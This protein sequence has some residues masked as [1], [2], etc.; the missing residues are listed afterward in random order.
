MVILSRD[1]NFDVIVEE[2][3]VALNKNEKQEIVI[4]EKYMSWLEEFTNSNSEI[5]TKNLEERE[6]V[7][8]NEKVYI[9]KLSLLFSMVENY[10]NENFI[11][12]KGDENKIIYVIMHFF[13]K[14]QYK[15]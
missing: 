13:F 14:F 3:K 2:L 1:D 11:F 8:L 15:F 7:S 4:N 12:P 10:A 9:T 5:N 6:D